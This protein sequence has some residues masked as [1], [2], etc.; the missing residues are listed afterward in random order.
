MATRPAGGFSFLCCG[1]SP[2]ASFHTVLYK[3]TV[4]DLTSS[5]QPAADAPL[6]PR[7]TLP[8][9]VMKSL[10]GE[11]YRNLEFDVWQDTCKGNARRCAWAQSVREEALY[12]E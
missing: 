10:D 1:V 5:F 7:L 6:A 4:P 9:K 11:V 12:H 3:H 8:Y 2:C